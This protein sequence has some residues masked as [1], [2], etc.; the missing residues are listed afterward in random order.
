[1]Y[2]G[3]EVMTGIAI[4]IACLMVVCVI[5]GMIIVS[6][7]ANIRI[8]ITKLLKLYTAIHSKCQ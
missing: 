8:N 2:M 3:S 6:L 4:L 5:F 1:M 7:L